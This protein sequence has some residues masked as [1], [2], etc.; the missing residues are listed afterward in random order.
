MQDI[1]QLLPDSIANQ[2]AAGEVVQRPSS[3]VKELME[4]AIDAKATKIKVI[5]KDAGKGFIQ[6]IDNGIGMS[7]TDA[8]L[9]FERHATSKIRKAEDL[10]KI[11]TM[12]F[13]GEALASIASVAQVELI[14][15]RSSEDLGTLIRIEASSFKS[16]ES[17]AAQNGTSIKV[18][19]L[20]YNIPARRNFL[21]SN[22]VEIRHILEEFQRLALA[23]PSIQF[24][25]IQNGEETYQLNPEKLGKRIVDLFGK[26]YREQLA[27]C[28]E[29]TNYLKIKGYIGKPEMAKKTRGE[30]FIFVNNRFIKSSYINHAIVSAY[31]QLIPEGHHPFYVLFLSID[32]NHID[33]NVHP[34]KTEIKFED[35]KSI[36]AL[37]HSTVRKTLSIT[38]MAH[39]IDFGA[40]TNLL[41]D[42]SKPQNVLSS[43]NSQPGFQNKNKPV[44]ENWKSLYQGLKDNV[45]QFEQNKG[46]NNQDLFILQSKANE[47]EAS[48]SQKRSFELFKISAG[49]IGMVK[50]GELFIL[51]QKRAYQRIFYDQFQKSLLQKGT[52]SQQLLF[53]YQ[54]TIAQTDLALFEENI[55]LFN[56]FGFKIE[57]IQKNH[58]QIEGIPQ[59][60]KDLNIEKLIQ[61]IMEQIK[62]EAG[63]FKLNYQE[64]MSILLANKAAALFGEK[65]LNPEEL[66]ALVEQVFA[67]SNPNYSPKGE[68]ILVSFIQENLIE[69]FKP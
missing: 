6:V 28:E 67:S 37:V 59:D 22:P 57:K 55:N 62:L 68:K 47:M 41:N 52:Y 43:N 12:G 17:T 1:I 35:E 46:Q 30:Q 29:D 60:F 26:A 19:N 53:P 11:I 16:Q 25:F 54:I 40:N 9:S 24:N 66:T 15:K 36:Y 42:L 27:P 7:E 45:S 31:E 64:N 21:K 2:I 34:T 58:F 69:L 44:E 13:R 5:I 10:F 8:R 65:T 48:D 56:K 14:T 51:H 49:F 32:P 4:N 18:S 39:S 50:S 23:N 20:F 33:I 63:D 3:V 61:E 38:N